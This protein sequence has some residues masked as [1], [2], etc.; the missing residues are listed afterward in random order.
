MEHAEEG[1]KDKVNMGSS[2]NVPDTVFHLSFPKLQE[3]RVLGGREREEIG[4]G[5]TGQMRN[6]RVLHSYPGARWGFRDIY[7]IG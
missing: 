3:E 4:S 5:T 2:I 1:I 7:I 6:K